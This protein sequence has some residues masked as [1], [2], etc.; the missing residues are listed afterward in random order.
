M[1]KYLHTFPFDSTDLVLL[2]SAFLWSSILAELIPV[3]HEVKHLVL[4]MGCAT[5]SLGYVC[6]KSLFKVVTE[7]FT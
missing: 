2:L 3:L 1:I 5:L 7:T 4:S 6:L